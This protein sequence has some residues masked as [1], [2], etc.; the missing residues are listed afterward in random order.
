M[1][2]INEH[3]KKRL[4]YHQL[5]E[6]LSPTNERYHVHNKRSIDMTG[7]EAFIDLILTDEE[8]PFIEREND[9]H[10]KRYS[11]RPGMGEHLRR[12]PDYCSAISLLSPYFTY[13]EQIELFRE[14]VCIAQLMSCKAFWS[15]DTCHVLI[16]SPGQYQGMT[17][18]EL[19]NL[20]VNNL[21]KIAKERHSKK[22]INRQRQA[23]KALELDYIRYAQSLFEYRAK[24]LVLRLDLFYRSEI[25]K[26]ITVERA[27][28]DLDRLLNNRRSNKTIFDGMIG[29]IAKLE[30]GILKGLHWHVIFFFDASIRHGA[31]HVYY[32]QQIGEYWVDCITHGVGSFW[33]CQ[34]Q[35]GDFVMLGTCGIGEIHYSDQDLR[36]NL[37]LRVVSYLCKSEQYFRLKVGK[38][39]RR[40]RRGQTPK[41]S[42]RGRPRQERRYGESRVCTHHALSALAISRAP[43]S[44]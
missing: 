24:L 22:E 19:F 34:T 15:L 16:D 13:S 39:Q 27:T 6:A 44:V 25:A 29:Y 36:N 35:M 41:R 37:A 40:I 3:W 4:A 7:I 28:E 1:K 33:N 20:F 43:E 31:K 8:M 2:P 11:V 38:D 14:A 9:K 30:Y 10:G 18:A 23:A 5:S 12:I 21:R 32:A 17:T 42:N 26:T